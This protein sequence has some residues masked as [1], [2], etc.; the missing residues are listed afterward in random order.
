MSLPNYRRPR[1]KCAVRSFWVL[2]QSARW[3]RAPKICCGG[4][5][6]KKKILS[7]CVI[8]RLL[9]FAEWIRDAQRG[10]DSKW[11]TLP[12]NKQGVRKKKKREGGCLLQEI[13]RQNKGG[14]FSPSSFYTALFMPQLTP[15]ILVHSGGFNLHSGPVIRF[16]PINS[17]LP[18]CP[19][20]DSI[21]LARMGIWFLLFVFLKFPGEGRHQRRTG[22]LARRSG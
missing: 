11:I 18:T 4:K 15:S 3:R 7:L 21:K 17:F 2:T 9:V 10:R 6:R 14:L 8:C 13:T 1:S 19:F 22:A 5:P 20:S 12:L 16:L